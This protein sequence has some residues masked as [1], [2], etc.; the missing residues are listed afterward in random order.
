[1]PRPIWKLAT[2]LLVA[3][4][5]LA[6]CGGGS[7]E[8]GTDTVRL[9]F[10]NP[11]LFTTGFPFYVARDQGFY[12]DA[13]LEVEANFTGGGAETVQTVVSGSSDIGT[14]TS[15]PAAIGA[16]SQGAPIKII[17]ASTTGLDLFWF[18]QADGPYNSREDLAGQ[19]VGYSAT[20]SS[21]HVGVLSLSDE[22]VAQGLEA[23]EAEAVGGPSE[24][25]TAVQTDQI[26]AGWSQPPFFLEEVDN[27]E[28]GIVARGSDIG[29]YRDVAVRVNIVNTQFA[30]HNPE[31][32]RRFLEVQQRA[33]DWIFDNPEEA[34][35][36]WKEA[37]E[38]AESE[39]MLLTSFDYYDRETMRLAPLDGQETL[40]EDARR[41]GFL[42]DDLS[43]GQI[44]ELFDLSYLPEEQQ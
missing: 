19:K 2:V 34:V 25:Y 38:L 33:W 29:E 13:G 36:V 26:A 39:E 16:F 24:N 4:L 1:M 21:S 27:G 35:R 18:A 17:S 5:A 20:G 30:E 43:E 8:G 28:L 15:A 9:A 31:T 14:E 7:Q 11:T 32:V 37:A 3:A 10:S 12:E 6:G 22:L 44:N 41:F 42:E 23:I 40:I